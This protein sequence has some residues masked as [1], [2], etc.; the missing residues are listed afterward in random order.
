M[1][2][3]L[4]CALFALPVIL[5]A[6]AF[7]AGNASR[8]NKVVVTF[9]LG[10]ECPVS[11][12]Y[13]PRIK[14]L[15]REFTAKGI[16]FRAVFPQASD[17]AAKVSKFVKE[18]GFSFDCKLD[19]GGS[20]AR[21]ASVKV[22]PTVSVKDSKGRV[23]Y[24]GSI[25]D[26]KNAGLVKKRYL[27]TALQE[28]LANKPVTTPKTT[29]VGCVFTPGSTPPPMKPATYADNVA[30]IFNDHCGTCHR[31]GEVAPFSLIGYENAKNWAPTIALVTANR[32]MPPWKAAPGV[33]D[34]AHEN[35]LTDE[36]IALLK[37]WADKGAPRGDAK[38]E[39]KPPA[40]KPG[41]AI[42][43]PDMVLQMEK[44]F[45]VSADGQDE[46]WHFILRPNVKEPRF[47]Q[48]VDVRPGNKK[49]VHHVILW[50]DE[51]GAADKVMAKK[52]VDG[53]YLTF[54]S[55]GF[56]PDNSLGGWAPG[57]MP[58]RTPADSGFLLKPGA[59][60]VLEVHYHKSGKEELDQT[61]IGL[62]FAKDSKKVTSP[63][64]I[65]WLANPFIRIK[66]GLAGQRFQQTIP[67]PVD[68]KLYSLMPHMHLLGREMSATLIHPDGSEEKLIQVDDWD[69]NWQFTYGL[70]APMTIKKGS[71][72]RIEAV[73]D[74][75][76][77]NPNNPSDPPREVRWGEQ[78][79]D[80][81]MLM[82][83]AINIP[84][85]GKLKGGIGF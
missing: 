1:K 81:M 69:F 6:S 13:A 26:H 63:L 7:T 44:P 21:A 11:A 62:Y 73:Y 45:K 20:V 47:V 4:K 61:K 18:R 32:K 58:T 55:P 2:T 48:A 51:K 10:T 70:K 36:E 54:G 49:I 35:R 72:L 19:R 59:T 71:K 42:G 68:V 38:K 74:N 16:E 80:E 17:D 29:P 12:G 65:A 67:I 27:Q 76:T 79:T 22:V 75:S 82:V 9:F 56:I 66:P 31:P 43:E 24:F 34:F 85:R 84:D 25:D 37:D 64:E 3:V 53:A 23:L 33:G 41:W 50:I 57:M 14:A 28:I 8:R 78:T 77:A 15:T 40:F 46:Y 83:A 5:V 52:G 60:I 30:K 39:P